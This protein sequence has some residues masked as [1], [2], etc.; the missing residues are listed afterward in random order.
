MQMTGFEP[1]FTGSKCSYFDACNSQAS[2]EDAESE[3]LLCGK[4]GRAVFL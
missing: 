2:G 3:S 1:R 4:V